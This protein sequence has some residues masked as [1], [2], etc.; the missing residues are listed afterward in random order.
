MWLYWGNV[1]GLWHTSSY[2]LAQDFFLGKRELRMV[3]IRSCE[4]KGTC[5]LFLAKPEAALNHLYD[6]TNLLATE[7]SGNCMGSAEAPLPITLFDGPSVPP[8]QRS[9]PFLRP[10]TACAPASP[11]LPSEGISLLFCLDHYA[12]PFLCD[13]L[14]IARWYL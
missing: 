5:H 7:G 10:S 2:A 3:W 1:K 11:L 12:F 8:S 9:N 6:N 14:H 4:G 13:T